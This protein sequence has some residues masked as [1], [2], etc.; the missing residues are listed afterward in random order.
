M[1]RRD[2]I[3]LFGGAAALPI[4]ARA[5][6]V[7]PTRRIGVLIGLAENDPQTKERLAGFREGLERRGWIEGHNLKINTALQARAQTVIS[8]SQKNWLPN[9]PRSF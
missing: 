2:F 4:M 9:D 7:E 3:A 6:Q 1:R 8:L 5:Q